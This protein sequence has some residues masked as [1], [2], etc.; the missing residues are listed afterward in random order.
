MLWYFA[1]GLPQDWQTL[2]RYSG[3]FMVQEDPAQMGWP[4]ITEHKQYECCTQVNA[5]FFSYLAETKQTG[6]QFV[7]ADKNA[8]L[9]F[10]VCVEGIKDKPATVAN[11]KAALELKENF[12][13][14]CP[15]PVLNAWCANRQHAG[16]FII[17]HKSI[18][19]NDAFKIFIN[20]H[21]AA[22][23]NRDWLNTQYFARGQI[24]STNGTFMSIRIRDKQVKYLPFESCEAAKNALECLKRQENWHE[25]EGNWIEILTCYSKFAQNAN[26][27]EIVIYE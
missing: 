20:N 24:F 11:K 12:K 22:Q 2:E 15:L 13:D 16:C 17:D 18:D 25:R 8:P 7:R 3:C 6:A 1:T 10:H 26:T 23:W 27:E 4:Q 14:F 21:A 5:D 9:I 19:G